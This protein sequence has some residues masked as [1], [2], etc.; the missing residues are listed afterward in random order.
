MVVDYKATDSA[1]TNLS[2]VIV[3]GL[4][5]VTTEKTSKLN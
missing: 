4:L 3:I 5:Y 2:N 1:Y